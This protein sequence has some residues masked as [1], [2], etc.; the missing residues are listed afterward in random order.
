MRRIPL[1]LL[2][3]ILALSACSKK[4]EFPVPEGVQTVR[5]VLRPVPFS[6]D[7][8]GTHALVGADGQIAAYAE[9]TAVNLRLL[10]G[11]D[12]ELQGIFEK[13]IDPTD[14]PVLVVQKVLDSGGELLRPWTI[15]ALSLSLDLP[16]DWKGSL[17]GTSAT[18]TA[19]GYTAPVLTIIQRRPNPN[20]NPTPTYGPAA[21]PSDSELL[22]VGLRK[23]TATLSAD[24][25]IWKVVV[26]P[27]GSSPDGAE[28]E[29]TFALRAVHGNQEQLTQYRDVMR[30]VEFKG[31]AFSARAASQASQ[32]PASSLSGSA[33]SR[34]TGEG[35]PCGGAAGIL[36]LSGMYCKIT[37]LVSESGVCAKR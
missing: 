8:R 31:S 6:L 25:Q 26:A 33:Q 14:L 36:C 35:A 13:N 20:P 30:S 17:K 2:I 22:V 29:F 11:R 28:T 18:F 10:E 37:D 1:F 34:A 5:A 19:S 3:G 9:S 21:V 24:V 12:V 4:P 27:P 16:R 15:P 23:A 32:R 7:R